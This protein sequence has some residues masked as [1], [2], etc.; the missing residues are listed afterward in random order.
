MDSNYQDLWQVN[1]GGSVLAY[2]SDQQ[3]NW[4]TRIQLVRAGRADAMHLIIISGQKAQIIYWVEH[5][6]FVKFYF[7]STGAL[8]DLV[9]GKLSIEIMNGFNL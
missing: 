2:A 5:V 1:L 6:S 3:M 4:S 7:E 8:C 9:A